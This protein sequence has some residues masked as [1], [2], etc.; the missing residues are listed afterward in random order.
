MNPNNNNFSNTQG[1]GFTTDKPPTRHVHH[2]SAEPLPGARGAR[3]P[4]DY[5]VDNVESMS[6]AHGHHQGADW[7]QRDSFRQP[8]TFNPSADDSLSSQGNTAFTRDRPMNVQPAPEGGVSVDGQAGLPE[9]HAGFGDKLVG[10]TQKVIGKASNNPAL[11]EKGELR[12]AGGKA[13]AEG[14]ARAPHD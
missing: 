4:I 3:D 9:G 10:K 11:H 13:A 12:E 7:H 1:A 6:S 14:L 2:N 5:S 8:G